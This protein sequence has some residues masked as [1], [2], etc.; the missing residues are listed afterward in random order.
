MYGFANLFPGHSK[1]KSVSF[2]R[3]TVYMF[4]F[5]I[6][7]LGYFVKTHIEEIAKMYNYLKR[8]LRSHTLQSYIRKILFSRVVLKV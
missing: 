6:M 5:I 4:W 7:L 3:H 1:K 2:D 8:V